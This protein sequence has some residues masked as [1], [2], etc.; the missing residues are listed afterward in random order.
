MGFLAFLVIGGV[1]GAGAWGFYPNRSRQ[2]T[3]QKLLMAA[4]LGFLAALGASYL[5]QFAQFFQ[6]GQMLEWL[7][8]IVAASLVGGLYAALSR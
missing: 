5:G 2:N 7:C 6:A 4:S 8:T 3:S 1:S